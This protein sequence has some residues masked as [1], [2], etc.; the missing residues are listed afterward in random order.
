MT[1]RTLALV[2]LAILAAS[3]Q[4]QSQSLASSRCSAK[5]D[6]VAHDAF[7]VGRLDT[8]TENECEDDDTTLPPNVVANSG[9]K[10]ILVSMLARSATF[11]RQCRI[12]R[13]SRFV[14]ITMKLTCTKTGTYRAIT[15]VTRYQAGLVCLAMEFVAPGN[16]IELIGHEFEH[17]LEQAEGIDITAIAASK[18]KTAYMTAGGA[19]ET[20]RA[21]SAG[22][23]VA[24]EFHEH[25]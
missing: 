19:F 7:R 3:T 8:D 2:C 18:C 11:R 22:R 23:T 21:I 17:A 20:A 14:R 4:S 25:R 15:H 12:I 24:R 5:S 10:E 6:P 13:R 9:L 1:S 16:Y